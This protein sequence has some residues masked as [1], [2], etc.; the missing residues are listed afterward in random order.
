MAVSRGSVHHSLGEDFSAFVA[1]AFRP[2]QCAAR[3]TFEEKNRPDNCRSSPLRRV[4][5]DHV[6]VRAHLRKRRA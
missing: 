2:G 5:G 4:A 3:A 6:S 1:S